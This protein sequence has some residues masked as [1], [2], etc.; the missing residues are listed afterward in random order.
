MSPS[1]D[2]AT[3]SAAY[4]AGTAT[5]TSIIGDI[6]GRIDADRDDGVWITVVPRHH[7][8]AR[9][10][11]LER[12]TPLERAELPLFWLRPGPAVGPCRE[13]VRAALA[14]RLVRYGVSIVTDITT[15]AGPMPAF[16]VPIGDNR[17]YRRPE[18]YYLCPA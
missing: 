5:P 10:R 13:G 6:A 1:L 18:G 4:R 14:R 9:A 7:L 2:I 12:L 16:A 15:P 8:L 3:L 11:E 17:H